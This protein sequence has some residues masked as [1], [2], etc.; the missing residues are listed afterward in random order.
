MSTRKNII[1]LETPPYLTVGKPD[2]AALEV[3]CSPGHVCSCCN[4][5][6][7]IWGENEI[8]EPIHKDCPV[9]GG[10]GELEAVVTIEWKP[11]K[12]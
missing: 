4:G 11:S 10:S 5:N 7:W 12:Q 9:C 6:G 8:G 1:E 3:F 2:E